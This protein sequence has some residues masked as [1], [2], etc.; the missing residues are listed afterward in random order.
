MQSNHRMKRKAFSLK[1]YNTFGLEAFAENFILINHHEELIS[2]LSDGQMPDLI[3]GGGSNILF[4]GNTLKRVFKN[5]ILGKK[6]IEINNEKAII[7]VGGGE[8]WH[9]LVL[10]TLD[11]NLGGIENLSLIPGTVGAAPIQNIGAYGVE[12]KDVFHSLDA[13]DL[14]ENKHCT[15]SREDCEFSYRSSFFKKNKGRYFITKVR[16]TLSE[17]HVLNT[18]YG[19]I[20]DILDAKQI[21]APG[22]REVSEAVI[23]IRTAKLPDPQMIGNAGSFFKNPLIHKTEFSALQ[24]KFPEIIYYPAGDMVKIPA[25]WLIEK[26][27]FKGRKKGAVGCYEKQAL[28]IVN[29][30]GASGQE[31]IAWA[32]KIEKAVRDT[33]GI[34]LEREVNV[35]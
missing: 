26:C 9:D 12:L 27:G 1:N 2:L 17:N 16:L 7:E 23:A 30:G 19:A 13:V 25:G 22:I 35:I 28:V 5:N 21:K 31:V 24:L 20:A 33:F 4:S 34:Q 15:F 14:L 11:Q 10:W 18:S 3:L 6:I 29:F 8:N 32:E